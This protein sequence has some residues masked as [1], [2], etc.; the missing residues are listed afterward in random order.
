MSA[1][2]PGPLASPCVNICQMDERSGLCQGCQRSI[3]EIAAWSAASSA[4]K[5]AILEAVAQR[6]AALA[7][8]AAH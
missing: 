3:E 7:Q 1:K 6:R 2:T 8:T 5:R 4:Q